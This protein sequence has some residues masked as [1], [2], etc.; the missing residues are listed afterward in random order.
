MK[1]LRYDWAHAFLQDGVLG[2]DAWQ[3]IE[4]ACGARGAVGAP[5]SGGRCCWWWWFRCC[6]GCPMLVVLVGRGSQAAEKH[7][8]FSQRDIH[9]FLS[10][11]W[12]YSR[13]SREKQ[14]D[15][16]RLFSEPGRKAN[17][18][19]K[20]IK[21]SM[22]ELLG[23]YGLLRHFVEPRCPAGARIAAQL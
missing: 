3:L 10:E 18:E 14:R 15:L 5:A 8:V 6:L 19:S 1:V 20:S 23:L 2:S 22:D 12:M 7:S 4:A 11:N 9:T 17:A 21:A 16:V 13:S